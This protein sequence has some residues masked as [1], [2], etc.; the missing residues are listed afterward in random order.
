MPAAQ[1][2]TVSIKS[3]WSFLGDSLE[4]ND[5]HEESVEPKAR[6]VSTKNTTADAAAPVLLPVAATKPD[7]IPVALG[8]P[9]FTDS[10]PYAPAEPVEPV[11]SSA[12]TK[13]RAPSGSQVRAASPLVVLGARTG[14]DPAECQALGLSVPAVTPCETSAPASSDTGAAIDDMT[15]V[16]PFA[17]DSIAP[18][19]DSK[20]PKPQ[21]S[22]IAIGMRLVQVEPATPPAAETASGRSEIASA[23]PAAAHVEQQSPADHGQSG[24]Q[25]DASP[26]DGQSAANS[27]APAA[28]VAPASVTAA[29]SVP[30]TPAPAPA[31]SEAPPALLAQPSPAPQAP[32]A[33]TATGTAEVE[34]ATPAAQPVSRDVSLHLGEADSGVNIRLAE[35]GGEIRVTVDT[36]DRGLANSLRADLPDL[37]GKLR[38]NGFEAEAWHPASATS[39]DG[40]RRSSS[41]SSQ[42]QGNWTEARRDGRQRQSQPQEPQ[43][44][45]QS[46][47]AGEWKSTF[48]P[49]LESQL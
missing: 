47:W 49:A 20:E 46:R 4:E 6:P 42:S 35:R 8:F 14:S 38:Q 28:P 22:E 10:V 27:T 25:N 21:A 45:N 16:V 12:D 24:S 11:Q 36:P 34:P 3:F 9:H 48:G 2:S 17:A 29:S 7:L 37:V 18:E 39:S 31:A 13:Q 41:D 44:K 15:P 33:P 26:R 43:S 32:P 5:S 19:S 30:D 23:I 40:G 1:A